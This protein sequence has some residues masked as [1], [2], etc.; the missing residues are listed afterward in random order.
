VRHAQQS[1]QQAAP[2]GICG[3]VREMQALQGMFDALREFLRQ[4]R[5]DLKACYHHSRPPLDLG[6]P[7]GGSLQRTDAN[8]CPPAA[9]RRVHVI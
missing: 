2:S 5:R 1:E 8:R 4:L 7:P 9:V 3:A 6:C